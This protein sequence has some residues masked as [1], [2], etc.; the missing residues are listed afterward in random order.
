MSSKM[1][2]YSKPAKLAVIL[3]IV[4]LVTAGLVFAGFSY[5][6]LNVTGGKS[7]S[8]TAFTGSNGVTTTA[9][10]TPS[11]AWVPQIKVTH[12][13]SDST[14]VAG[15]AY[16]INPVAS[17]WTTDNSNSPGTVV[18]GTVYTGAVPIAPSNGYN[19][20]GYYLYV[21]ATKSYPEWFQVNSAAA[22]WSQSFAGINGA[23]NVQC[24][25]TSGNSNAYNWLQTITVAQGPGAS[26][27]DQKVLLSNPTGSLPTAFPTV[28]TTWNIVTNLY[29][30]YKFA[31]VPA[32]VCGTYA[33]TVVQYSPNGQTNTIN[34]GCITLQTEYFIAFNNTNIAVSGT[35]GWSLTPVTT[36]RLAAGTEAFIVTSSTA[37][38]PA[39]A[40]TGSNNAFPC[41]TIPVQVQELS[42]L[43]HHLN[44]V[45]T[46]IDLQ[47]PNYVLNY[48]NTPA[49]TSW[50]STGFAAD[51]SLGV[52]T[53]TI[54]QL[55][56]FKLINP[57]GG[58]NANSPDAIL[59]VSVSYC[60]TD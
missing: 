39:P 6:G 52:A 18:D 19:G 51:T 47:Q 7:T 35:A 2:Y 27:S 38:G 56:G 40:S 37:C 13:S 36:N 24:V 31:S 25:P 43:G 60:F 49:P 32:T 33:S 55:T 10:C 28:Q 9:S 58:S 29:Q 16:Y 41:A 5:T 45:I 46:A 50:T 4:I 21:N 20:N 34:N 26:T 8:T 1:G 53:S 23:F 44:M 48:A 54:G 42:T 30:P 57:I 14:L 3:T 15:T 12:F 59:Y 11:T 17:G 22:S